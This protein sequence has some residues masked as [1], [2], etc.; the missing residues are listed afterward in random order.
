MQLRGGDQAWSHAG[1]YATRLVACG[2]VAATVRVAC[3]S[4]CDPPGR[5]QLRGGDRPGRIQVRVGDQQVGERRRCMRPAA[6]AGTK[7]QPAR[8]WQTTIH[9]TRT[10]AVGEAVKA[11]TRRGAEEGTPMDGTDR[12]EHRRRSA[13][14]TR[15]SRKGAP[16]NARKRGSRFA[17][18]AARD[19]RTQGAG[20]CMGRRPIV[21]REVDRGPQSGARNGEVDRGQRGISRVGATKRKTGRKEGAQ[22]PTHTRTAQATERRRLVRTVSGGGRQEGPARA[23]DVRGVRELRAVPKPG[24]G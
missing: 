12:N 23:Q 6:R 16:G 10:E 1:P 18:S 2:S 7:P 17:D 8:A 13:G 15:R 19:E 5:M 21:D 9:G 4:V 11:P 22:R 20:T 24:Q 14:H 3:K